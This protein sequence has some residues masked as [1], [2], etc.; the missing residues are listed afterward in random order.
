MLEA[1]SAKSR[2][3]AA[4]LLSPPDRTASTPSIRRSKKRSILN[5]LSPRRVSL[6]Y[7]VAGCLIVFAFWIPHLFYTE[8]TLKALLYQQAVT[9]VVAIAFLIPYTTLNFDLT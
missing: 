9:G 3:V 2:L 5:S 4:D 8:I 1:D 7:I 6:L